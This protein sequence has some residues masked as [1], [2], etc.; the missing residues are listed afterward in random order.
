MRNRIITLIF[1]IML[2]AGIIIGAIIPDKYYSETEKRTLKQFPQISSG[3]IF[4]GNFGD[5]I[6]EYLEDQ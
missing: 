3:E 1:C 5:D 6:E 4:S 2:T